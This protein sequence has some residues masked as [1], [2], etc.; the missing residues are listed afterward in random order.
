M[1]NIFRN[2]LLACAVG[3]AAAYP[4]YAQAPARAPLTLAADA[5]QTYTVVKGDTLWDISGQF[6][7]E[8]WLWPEIWD[9]N[10]EQIKNPHLIYPGDVIVLNMVNGNPRLSVAGRGN[11]AAGAAGYGADDGTQHY[12]GARLMPDGTLKL[13]PIAHETDIEEFV[14]SIPPAAITPFLARPLVDDKDNTY[15]LPY[16][17]TGEDER[18]LMGQGDLIYV[19][20]LRGTGTTLQNWQI[21]RPS[22]P[23]KDPE[24]GKTIAYESLFLGTA[25]T[26]K[27]SPDEDIMKMTIVQATAEIQRGDRLQ[28]SEER[29]ILSYV[30]HRPDSEI[31][32]R[33][34]KTYGEY[35]DGQRNVLMGEKH[36]VIVLNRGA[37]DGLEMGHVLALHRVHEADRVQANT[38][39][40]RG[41]V[42]LPDERYGLVFVFRTFD[43]VSYALVM[44]TSRE[45]NV[46]DKLLVP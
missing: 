17:I 11:G 34:V 26:V 35:F 8:P 9:M 7:N 39:G 25:R 13:S 33:V 21:Y 40:T 38:Y 20:G 19:K 10:K 32:A 22:E 6:L 30:P 5:P 24:T 43:N 18:N 42:K 12:R 44:E 46:G 45:V 14:P 41:S 3:V 28:L 37:N 27:Y 16:V 1:H 36:K 31:Q 23:L 29:G 2:T 15:D 4:V